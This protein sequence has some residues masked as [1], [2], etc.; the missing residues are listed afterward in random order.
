MQDLQVGDQVKMCPGS[1]GPAS[2]QVAQL[3]PNKSV[4]LGHQDKGKWV[5]T[6]EFILFQSLTALIFFLADNPHAWSESARW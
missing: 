2:Y 1:F 4:V 6:W 5:D 3:T